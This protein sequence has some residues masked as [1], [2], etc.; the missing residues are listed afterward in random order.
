L[1]LGRFLA[2][3]RGKVGMIA[4]SLSYRGHEEREAGFQQLL[5][6]RFPELEIVG[7]REG[8]D[9]PER[10]YAQTRVLLAH[11]PDLVGLYNIGGST[12]G[13][14]RALKEAGLDQRV[15]LVGHELTPDTRGLLMDGTLDAVISQNPQ[16]EIMNCVRILTNLREHKEPLA[17]VEPLRIGIVLRENMP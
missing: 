7:L 11:H 9:D 5:H 6:E 13:I 1:L 4:G 15:T 3:R 14:G 2:G 12:G 8:H 17:G 10:N 16:I